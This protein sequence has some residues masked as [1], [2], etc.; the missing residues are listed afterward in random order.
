MTAL[1]G[2]YGKFFFLCNSV[3]C[4]SFLC[5]V[6]LYCLELR[7]SVSLRVSSKFKPLKNCNIQLCVFDALISDEQQCVHPCVGVLL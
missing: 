3:Y 5:C 2:V 7:E 4:V 1:F 6:A